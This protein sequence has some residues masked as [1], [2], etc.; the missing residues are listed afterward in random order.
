MQKYVLS[1]IMWVESIAKKEIEKQWGKI[2]EVTDR[3]L[4]FSW[5]LEMIPRINFWS[6]VGNKLYMLLW[7]TENITDFD[8]LFDEV[9]KINWKKYFKQPFPII[10]KWTSVRSELHSVPSL[11]WVTKKA[12]IESLTDGDGSFVREDDSLEPLEVFV[13]LVNNKLRILLNTS[14]NALHMRWYRQE[15]WEAPIKESLAAALVLL[16]GWRFKN[17]FYDP[18]CGSGTIAIEALMIAKNIAP[19]LQR[20]FAFESLWLVESDLVEGEREGAKKKEFQWKYNIFASDIDSEIIEVAKANARRAG[21]ENEID[22]STQD[23]RNYLDKKMEGTLVSNPPYGMRLQSNDI[24]SL[25]NT[26]DKLFR[27]NPELNGGVISSYLEFD[28]LIKKQDYKKRKLYNG[29][30]MCYFWKRV[31]WGM[32]GVFKRL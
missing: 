20:S 28:S 18:F 13:L 22:F 2:D 23:F 11:Q 31:P 9:K 10:V 4:V 7:E 12:I 16:S 19:W 6:R 1:T 8:T 3:L 17:N 30:E 21:L 15:A 14:G 26:I 25:Y 27:L 32:G 29:A 5:G 24:R